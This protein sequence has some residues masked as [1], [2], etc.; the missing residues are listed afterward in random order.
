[1]RPVSAFSLICSVLLLLTAGVSPASALSPAAP[2]DGEP[3]LH[4]RVLDPSGQPVAAARVSLRSASGTLRH[5][6]SLADGSFAF[7]GLGPGAYD[8]TAAVDG[9][10]A[11]IVP[12]VVEPGAALRI[13]IPLRLAALT[14]TI[15]VTASVI[16]VPR[17][18]AP[19]GVVALTRR[20]LE[21]RQLDTVADALR[22]VPGLAVVPTGGL[23]SVTSVFPRG[24]ESDFTLVLADGAKLNAFGGGIDF[25]HL[26]T[27]GIDQIEVVRGPQS[28]VFGADAVGGVIH[29]R[30]KVGGPPA[31]NTLLEAGS[32]G[33]TRA[34][35]GSTGS[36]GALDWGVSAERV[37]SDGWTG[38]APN[39]ALGR[40]TNDDYQARMLSA[41]AAW[42]AGSGSVVRASGRFGRNE[43]GYPGP[44]GADPIGAYGGIDAVSRG[45]N[46]FKA[47]SL[48]FTREWGPATAVRL[49]ASAGD[50]ESIFASP[51]G[52]SASRTRR[53]AARGQFDRALSAALS[54]SAGAAV[55][56]ERADS[57][58]ITGVDAQQ[59]PVKRRVEG[60]FAEL[61]WRSAS[62]LFVTA[63]LRVEH[64][65]RSA[66]EADPWAWEPRPAMKT[67]GL[68]SANPRAAFSY[69][70]RTSNESAGNWT[71]LHASAG[72]GIRPPAALEIAFTDNPGLRPE[73]SRSAEA[74]VEQALAGGLI[75]ADAT[76]FG[77]RYD[78]LIVAVGRALQDYSQFRSDN[79][80]NAR[81]GGVEASLALRTKLGL[82]FRAAYSFVD[83]AI[84]AVDRSTG[85]APAPFAVGDWLV[86][87]PRHQAS[88]DIV[89]RHALATL[90]V[91]AGGRSRVLDVEPNW[92]ASGGLFHSPGFAVANAGAAIRLTRHADLV[93]RA[94]NLF[95]KRYESAL[96]YPAP[97]R[98]LSAGVRLAARR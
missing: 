80:S 31:W 13:D 79:I 22:L 30:S 76:V 70:L 86:R 75:V 20:D 94:D 26:T 40:V 62:R 6:L 45:T 91:R 35:I 10:S 16:E 12:A 15:L 42:R 28:A 17:A 54:A 71:R 19:A 48:E 52:E 38:A 33:T 63:G 11:G 8:L 67:D 61:R 95:D 32:R 5:T 4:G 23:G 27:F 64:I 51:Y 25:G 34:A 85:T 3:S 29:L 18:E 82:E 46:T 43:R 9:F 69:Y 68:V 72:T 97:R 53:Y 37:E 88:A 66:L 81:A 49:H 60:Y 57:T 65:V 58:F 73:R 83:T 50:E 36:V 89:W 56:F 96:G 90:Y 14:D 44:F 98:A 2:A 84:L 87:R 24:G 77:N 74:G 41:A 21:D 59:V 39:V 7:D 93:V 47:G 1:V 55:E 92:G 78:D